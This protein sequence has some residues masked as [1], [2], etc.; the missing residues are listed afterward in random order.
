L[1]SAIATEQEHLAE[2]TGVSGP[3]KR[4][5]AVTFVG[6]LALIVGSYLTVDGLVVLVHGGD[7]NKLAAG[8]FDLALGVLAIAIGGGTLQMR[9]WAWAAFMTWAVIGLTHQILRHFFYGHPNYLAMALDAVVVLALT[10]LDVQIA[11]G[12]RPPRNVILDDAARNP[13][14]SN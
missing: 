11:F 8:A 6:V 10:P 2:G 4:P 13:I 12:V 5:I 14:G 3:A 9:R 1:V 7:A